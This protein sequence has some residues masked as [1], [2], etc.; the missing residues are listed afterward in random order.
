MSIEFDTPEIAKRQNDVRIIKFAGQRE[1]EIKEYTVEGFERT[2]GLI[3]L[4]G[5]EFENEKTLR[6]ISK[7]CSHASKNGYIDAD[8]K[9]LGALY[10]DQ[11]RS[12]NIADVSIR[13][14]DETLG[15][16][17]FAEEEI[18]VREYIGEYTGVI[19][20]RYPF[21][22]KKNDYRFVYPTSFFY[23][24]KHVIDAREKGNEIRY[25]NHSDDPNSEA[26]S[27]FCDGL[28]HIILRALKDI[29]AN[30]QITYNYSERYWKS[31]RR[32]P[33]VVETVSFEK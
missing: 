23:I 18:K 30:T 6:Q 21:S 10:V 8:R 14:I 31:R 32:V 7:Q 26:I 2:V 20:K 13:W 15:Y 17:L 24:G 16:G 33:N 12:H 5:L 22:V 4:H 27:V 9:W 3:F 11:I 1:K 25:A 29:P 19:H 28:F